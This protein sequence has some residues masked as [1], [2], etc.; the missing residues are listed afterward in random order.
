MTYRGIMALLIL[1]TFSFTGVTQAET[2]TP[3]LI[4]VK[5]HGD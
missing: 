1:I 4:A 5:F 3:K 2:S